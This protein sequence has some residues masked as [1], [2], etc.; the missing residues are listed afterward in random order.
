MVEKSG[1]RWLLVEE[2]KIIKMVGIGG[3]C[4]E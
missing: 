1:D 4:M 3:G 2:A